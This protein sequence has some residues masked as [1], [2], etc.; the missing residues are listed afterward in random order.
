VL[1]FKAMN[2][3]HRTIDRNVRAL[4]FD[5]DGTLLQV[6]MHRF[7]PDYLAD[8]A[9]RF[10]DT[11]PPER[12]TRVA[13]R[14]VHHLLSGGDEQHT[15]RERYLGVIAA[16]LSINM[17]LFE[18][19]LGEWIANGLERLAGHVTPIAAAR[20]LLDHCFGLGIPVVL[21][22]N[23][24]F[25]AAMIEARLAWGGLDGYPF[26]VITSYENTRYCKPQPE[27]F[28]DLL[29]ILGVEARHCLMVGN[30]T[31]H[32]LAASAV[33]IPT[34]LA[35]TYLVDRLDGAFRS[36]LRGSLADL[37][38]LLKPEAGPWESKHVS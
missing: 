5:L 18:E 20:P 4:F 15:N 13:H 38:R 21:A 27:Y 19:R 7:I 37:L 32:D 28:R 3:P 33:G 36:D 25:P 29:D 14:A 30:D 35:D 1:T 9:S 22:T 6:E 34:F 31:E 11:V 23:P 10:V 12:F 26:D 24:V 17:E 16:Q 8:L 2:N